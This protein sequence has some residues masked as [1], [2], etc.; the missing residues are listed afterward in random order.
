MRPTVP[1][2]AGTEPPLTPPSAPLP[3]D[4]GSW[5]LFSGFLCIGIGTLLPLLFAIAALFLALGGPTRSLAVV[6]IGGAMLGRFLAVSLELTGRGL[7]LPGQF[8]MK[9]GGFAVAATGL[10][11]LLLV[12]TAVESAAGRDVLPDAAWL[13]LFLVW[14]CTDAAVVNRCGARLPREV[15]YLTRATVA[16]VAFPVVAVL[17][18]YLG[19]ARAESFVS[20]AYS[21]GYGRGPGVGSA[22]S[23]GLA[24]GLGIGGVLGW[25]LIRGITYLRLATAARPVAVVALVAGR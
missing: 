4:P 1:D 20:E 22:L 15:T 21:G 11:V 14:V 12:L 10:E 3:R 17:F 9:V 8:R 24:I 5:L 25:V 16:L 19:A 23:T 13:A 6:L 7:C 2:Y 18:Q